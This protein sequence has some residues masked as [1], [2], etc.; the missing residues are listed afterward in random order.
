MNE[1]GCVPVNLF[2]KTSSSLN[3]VHDC[4]L[5]ILIQRKVFLYLI[6]N[7]DTVIDLSYSA[8]EKKKMPLGP[9]IN[10]KLGN[11]YVCMCAFIS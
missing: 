10:E 3:L 8:W 4:G 7:P 11:M 6:P 9:K 1:F 5:L 2:T